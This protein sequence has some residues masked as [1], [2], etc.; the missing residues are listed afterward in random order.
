MRHN[1]ERIRGLVEMRRPET[2]GE[3]MQFL[4][5]ANWIRLPLPNVAEVVTLLGT[6]LERK[7]RDPTRT[8]RVPSRKVI[9]EEDWSE[10]LQAAWQSSRELLRD[11]VQ[12]SFHK[13]DFRVVMFPDAID[14]LWGGFP[15][16]VPEEDFVSGIP[17]GGY[18]SAGS[19]KGLI[20]IG[21]PWTRK[22]VPF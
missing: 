20:S 15:T 8:K 14:L 19:S 9:S 17:G 7:L 22:H 4:Q 18:V 6:K 10:E 16:Q 21:L 5:A 3:L 1:P 11:A 13:R 12:L 2:V